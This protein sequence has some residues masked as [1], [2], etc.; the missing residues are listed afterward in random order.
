MSVCCGYGLGFRE[1][2]GCAC[3]FKQGR[4]GRR[5]WKAQIG[6]NIAAGPD[7]NE[8]MSRAFLTLLGCRPRLVFA[9]RDLRKLDACLCMCLLG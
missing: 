4:T 3:G 5:W 7:C 6:S 2:H 1:D 8:E 9:I